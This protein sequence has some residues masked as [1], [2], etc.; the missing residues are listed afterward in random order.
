MYR[1]LAI[2][3]IS[4]L[5]FSSCKKNSQNYGYVRFVF[6]HQWN[7]TLIQIDGKTEYVNAAN[8][9]LT[10]E[11]LEYFIS[12]LTISGSSKFLFDVPNIRYITNDRA[13]S[14]MQMTHQ[15]PVGSY[16]MVEFIFGLDSER[17]TSNQ[18]TDSPQK[19]MFWPQ[20]LGGGYHFM[21]LDGKWK[22]FGDATNQ[23]FGLHLGTFK[24]VWY[25]TTYIKDTL[26]QP[27]T[28]SIIQIRDTMYI[29]TYTDMYYNSFPVKVWRSFDVAKDEVT[30]VKIIMD[31]KQWMEEPYIWDFKKMRSEIMSNEN[32][33]DSLKKNGN[34][35]FR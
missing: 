34:S 11:N 31:V 12:D 17:N 15:V 5:L 32:A 16:S 29:N 27:L 8:N 9:I 26:R 20:E 24:K 25:D 10:F 1:F 2:L 3:G 18:F 6:E 4:L 33:L 21:K 23:P 7:D 19:D 30:E 35:V 14:T 28:D 13:Y 22:N